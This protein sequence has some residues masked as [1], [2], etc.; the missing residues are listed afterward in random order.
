M[1][2]RSTHANAP[3][4]IT[5]MKRGKIVTHYTKGTILVLALNTCLI[6]AIGWPAKYVNATLG[7][8]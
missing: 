5:R 4:N 1:Y 6:V 2:A 3:E 8:S 7:L